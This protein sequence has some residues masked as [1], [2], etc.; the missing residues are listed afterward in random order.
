MVLI[1][2]ETKDVTTYFVVKWLEHFD[3]EV[4]IITDEDEIEIVCLGSQ[5]HILVNGRTVNLDEVAAY[6]YR[7]GFFNVGK[8][9]TDL[10]SNIDYD[11]KMEYGSVIELL[12]YKLSAV[13]NLGSF[14]KADVNRIIV[15]EIAKSVGFSV[16]R[17]G[18]FGDKKKLEGFYRQ[19]KAIV[20]KPLWNGLS[21]IEENT[22]YAH[23]TNIFSAEDLELLPDK[24]FPGLFAEYIDKAYELRIFFLDGK[25]YSMAIL[26]QQD[27]QTAVDVRRYNVEKPNRNVP[28][29]LPEEISS[30]LT[31]LMNKL[32]LKIGA[33]DMIVSTRNEFV[34]LEVN[35]VGQFL[36]ISQ[37]C[38]Y[39]LEKEIAEYFLRKIY[40]N[41]GIN[42]TLERI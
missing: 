5:N 8:A 18:I 7:R 38:N 15:M 34:F 14:Y 20:N 37:T 33:I 42:K 2:S 6:W 40:E 1:L 36:N 4:Q 31:T 17:Y 11:I 35:P 9:G 22:L 13:P 3:A 24:F 30:K 25:C 21:F 23:Y 12:H 19:F 41:T 29:T 10:H 32:S 27:Q 26:S 28:Y 39:C 16:P